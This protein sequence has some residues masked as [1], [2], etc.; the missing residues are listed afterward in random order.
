MRAARFEVTIELLAQALHLPEGSRVARIEMEPNARSAA[1]TVDDPALPES[2][3]PH[4]VLPVVTLESDGPR[5]NW[6]LD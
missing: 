3:E 6:G 1:F 5:W 2:V 4:D